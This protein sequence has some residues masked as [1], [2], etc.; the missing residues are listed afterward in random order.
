[1]LGYAICTNNKAM[2]QTIEYDEAGY[3]YVIYEGN[4]DVKGALAVLTEVTS[5][6]KEYDCHRVL[7]DLRNATMNISTIHIYDLPGL[8]LGQAVKAGISLNHLKRAM[9]VPASQIEN[10]RF[11]ETVSFNRM[12]TLRLFRDVEEARAWLLAD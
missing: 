4:F 9:V 1:M 6:V 2:P 7:A 8:L 11:F 3:I 5:F 12:Q 10:F